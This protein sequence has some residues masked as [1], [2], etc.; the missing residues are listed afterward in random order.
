MVRVYESLSPTGLYVQSMENANPSIAKSLISTYNPDQNALEMD[1]VIRNVVG[2]AYVGTSCSC[3][4]CFTLNLPWFSSAGADTVRHCPY[5]YR[6]FSSK[7]V[8]QTVLIL[9]SFVLAMI[10]HPEAQEAAHKELD[11]VLGQCRAPT[12]DDRDTL[13]YITAISQEVLR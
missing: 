4:F 5:T 3:P 2:V 13:P 1:E 6:T 12:F 8:S 10:M 9:Q 7:N 11:H